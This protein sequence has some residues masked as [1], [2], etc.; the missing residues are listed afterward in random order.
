MDSAKK[1]KLLV[2]GGLIVVVVAASIV[3]YVVFRN[4]NQVASNDQAKW[5]SD[6]VEVKKD[7]TLHAD[8]ITTTE[9]VKTA[10][11]EHG[12]QLTGPE[13]TP[14]LRLGDQLSQTATYTFTMKN[15]QKATVNVDAHT[16]PS[17]EV[18]QTVNPFTN[19]EAAA[20]KGVGDEAHWL[21]KVPNPYQI[22]N[23]HDTLMAVKGTTSFAFSLEQPHDKVAIDQAVA[24]DIILQVAKQAKLDAVK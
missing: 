17:K 9:Q 23:P 7:D 19:T 11:G 14:V 15:G 1:K 4:S 21:K 10:L 6:F 2:I 18:M 13:T 5:G 8:K 3:L 20:V 12:S 22:T 24:R 16:Y